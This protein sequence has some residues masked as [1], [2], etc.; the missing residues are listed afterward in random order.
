MAEELTTSLSDRIGGFARPRPPSGRGAGV[1]WRPAARDDVDELLAFHADVARVDH[2]NWVESRDEVVETFELPH[3]D[4]VRDTMLAVG[5]DGRILASGSAVCPPGR[6]TLVRSIVLGAVRPEARRRGLGRALLGWQLA[7]AREQLAESG[8]PLP[9]WIMGYADERAPDAAALLERNGLSFRRSFFTL[10]R[11]LEA[12]VDAVAEPG[13]VR[14]VA[15]DDKWSESTRL[16]CNAA[17]VHHW[18]SQSTS[19]ESWTAMT[20]SERFAPD[21]SFLAVADDD[22]GHRVVV[23]F[24]LAI[25]NEGDWAGQGFTSAY[26]RIVGVVREWRG[27]RVARALLVRHLEATRASGLE[28]STLDVDA[29]NPAGAL[30]LY[31]GLGYEV[32]H[33]H[34]NYVLEY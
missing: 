14:I 3:I 23:G 13:G 4:P 24:V 16:A 9:G 17:F 7:R 15:W 34:L 21:L 18:G 31:S 25:R 6:E 29:E 20:S 1:V 10:E 5:A 22:D 2:P 28:R 12:P 11:D 8:E 19:V 33:T 32:A 30:G 26:V 27:R